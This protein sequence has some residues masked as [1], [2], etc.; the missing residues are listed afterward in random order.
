MSLQPAAQIS[1][2]SVSPWLHTT[3]SC[4]PLQPGKHV[5]ASAPWAAAAQSLAECTS[6]HAGIETPAQHAQ[7]IHTDRGRFKRRQGQSA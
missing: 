5:F 7:D 1:S 4:A 3:I 6:L 2:I